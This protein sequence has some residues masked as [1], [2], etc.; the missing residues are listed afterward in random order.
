MLDE[1]AAEDNEPLKFYDLKTINDSFEPALTEAIERVLRSGWYLLGAENR[2]FERQWADYCG[3]SHCVLTG[4]GM[5][6]LT[7]LLSA[8][9]QLRG[10]QDG[11][12]VIVPANT[13]I[14]TI[15]AVNAA[16]LKPV[17]C[18]PSFGDYLM[19]V[20][21]M[22]QLLTERT[23]AVIP[24]HLYGA[25]CDMD[26]INA[27]SR[28]HG[29]V[30]IE[31]AAQAHGA[32]YRGRRA[33]HLGDAAAFS[34]YP[35]K[36]LGALG[37]A[38]CITTDDEELATMVRKMANYGSATK[39]VNEVKG[40]NSRTDELQAAV[41]SVKLP[42]LDADNERR[43]QLAQIYMQGISN[44]LIVLPALPKNLEQ[45]VFYVFPVRCVA[46][47]ALQQYLKERGIGTLIHYPIPPHKQQAYPELSELRLPITERI[48]KE[49]LSLPISPLMSD[50]QV[51]RVVEVIN[52]FSVDM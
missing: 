42:R 18:E 22:K 1:P 27:W 50:A 12:E 30:V 39:Y 2:K 34:F 19:D 36:N 46:R 26:A 32:Q 5:D 45:H 21:E 51:R 33:G 52:D 47:E 14:A 25:V 10:W 43:R 3:A 17:L 6:A 35:G 38:G 9:K 8:Y 13:F 44:P 20:A 28:E 48:H 4:N 15:L 16:G 37:D 23:R 40:M 31:D 41:L 24:V 7:L 49:I 11:D 29:V